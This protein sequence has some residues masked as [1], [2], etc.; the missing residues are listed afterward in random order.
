MVGTAGA[1]SAG[2][3]RFPGAVSG[4]G[5]VAEDHGVLDATGR[6]GA[7]SGYQRSP[8]VTWGAFSYLQPQSVSTLLFD[9]AGPRAPNCAPVPRGFL[10]VTGAPGVAPAANLVKLGPA[11]VGVAGLVVP[12]ETILST[13]REV[14]TIRAFESGALLAR[15]GGVC[16]HTLSFYAMLGG[17][18]TVVLVH[19]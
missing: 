6:A 10:R 13:N 15:V 8:V 12:L 9:R 1:S 11:R 14:V 2:A 3:D 7:G 17:G 4:T 18:G 16:G 5:E 19:D